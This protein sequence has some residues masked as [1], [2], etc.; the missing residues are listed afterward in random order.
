MANGIEVARPAPHV[1]E[2][3]IAS[4][5]SN[6]MGDG[7]RPHLIGAFR[8]LDADTDIRAVILTGRGRMFTAGDDLREIPSR[9]ARMAASLAE[10]QV[11]FNLVAGLR[12]PVIGAINGPAFGGG[13][14]LALCCDIRIAGA[15]ARF[16]ASGVNT[17]L[18]ASVER[19]PRL[20]GPARAKSMLLTGQPIDAAAALAF[21]LVTAV[22]ADDAL[23]AAALALAT[24]IA[25]RAP[26]SVEAAKRNVDGRGAPDDLGL[27]TVSA[28]H[29]EAIAAFL[30]KRDPVFTRS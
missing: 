8:A 27:L 6:A 4:P 16:A 30:E 12:A 26:L 28:D 17:G 13:L 2:I 10:F 11:L 24:H 5:P 29:R 23:A 1:A 18:M 22:H 3:A 19:L 25:G 21:G 14:E 9:G 7:V 20:I 15:S